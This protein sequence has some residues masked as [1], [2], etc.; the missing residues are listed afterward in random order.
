[1]LI[2]GLPSQGKTAAV[3]LAILT[4]VPFEGEAA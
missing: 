2:G 3:R 4:G 1:V